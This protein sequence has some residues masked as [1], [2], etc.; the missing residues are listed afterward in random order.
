MKTAILSA[1]AVF[2]VVGSTFAGPSKDYKQTAPQFFQDNEITLDAFYS[3]NLTRHQDPGYADLFKND[4]CIIKPQYLNDG[5]GGGVGANYFFARYFGVGVEGNW[6]NGARDGMNEIT[7]DRLV[8]EGGDKVQANG[9]V[10]QNYKRQ[11]A[12]QISGDA[13]LRYPIEY[14]TFGLAPYILGGGGVILDGAQT[15]FADAGAG[16]EVRLTPHFGVF[17]DG[18][19]NFLTGSKNDVVTIRGGVRFVF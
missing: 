14:S 2:A 18:R 11:T 16:V 3:Y 19:Y 6:W 10:F 7:H 8:K 1:L 5:S 13:I 15:G 4:P 12:N 9:E 17:T